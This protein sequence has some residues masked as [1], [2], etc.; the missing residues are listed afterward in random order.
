[1]R[2]ESSRLARSPTASAIKYDG[3][4]TAC[5]KRCT[6]LAS[7]LVLA[8]AAAPSASTPGRRVPSSSPSSAGT[9]LMSAVR[10]AGARTAA[11]YGAFTAGESWHGTIER[12][13]IAWH[14]EK[15]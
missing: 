7:L 1:M 9:A 8:L 13:W 12:A 11:V 6:R 15:R 14:C 10:S 5:L 2:G 3:T 4:G